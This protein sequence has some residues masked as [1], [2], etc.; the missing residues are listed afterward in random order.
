MKNPNIKTKSAFFICLAGL[1]ILF[2]AGCKK[3]VNNSQKTSTAVTGPKSL[4]PQQTL[5]LLLIRLKMPAPYHPL[6]LPVRTFTLLR[7]QQ[8]IIKTAYSS[9]LQMH[10]V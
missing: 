3:D 4:Y 1:A 2:S 7:K 5:P 10:P 6:S 9:R 8:V